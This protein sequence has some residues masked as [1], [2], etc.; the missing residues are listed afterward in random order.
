MKKITACII[1]LFS[2]FSIISPTFAN[3]ESVF[4][5]LLDLNYWIEDFDL[6]LA[7]LDDISFRDQNLQQMHSDFQKS[8][9]QIKD[10][11]IQ[12]YRDGRFTEYQTQWIVRAHKNFVHYTNQTFLH[13]RYREINPDYADVN[14]N[15]LKNYTKARSSYNKIK[16]VI[17]TNY[18]NSYRTR[19]Y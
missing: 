2:V 7:R 13:M 17:N 11:I 6:E 14:G 10:E 15:I 19:Y 18:N 12:Y 8:N 9:R 3:D 5:Q 4:E 1:F 16:Q